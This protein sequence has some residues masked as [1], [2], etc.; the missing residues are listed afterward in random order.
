MNVLIHSE[1]ELSENLENI[2]KDTE[3]I[4]K[5]LGLEDSE[6]SILFVDYNRIKELNTTYRKK[7]S[8]TD[9]LSFPQNEG[10]L[11]D[12]NVNIL[13]DVVICY[14]RAV[15]QAPES[16]NTPYEEIMVLIIHSILH[17][18]GYDHI[19]TEE[20]EIMKEKETE[21]FMSLFN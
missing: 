18:I 17:L 21:I 9:V 11:S 10:I 12:I 16:D 1:V 7:N 5:Y 2:K 4:L 20:E 15:K 3:K 6:L 8:V 19:K 13:G 14:P